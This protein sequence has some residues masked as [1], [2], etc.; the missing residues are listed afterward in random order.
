MAKVS[1]IPSF[2]HALKGDRHIWIWQCFQVYGTT[3]LLFVNEN[4]DYLS[5]GA[6]FRFHPNGV[7]FNTPRGY[8][9]IYSLKS[10]VKRSSFYTS[11][12][13]NASDANTLNSIDI[14]LHAKKR[15]LLN[16][17]F[18]QKSVS[19]S[20]TFINKHVDR[21]HELL[22]SSSDNDHRDWTEPINISERL[23]CLVFDILGDLCFG[24][25]FEIVGRHPR[26]K[27]S[28]FNYFMNYNNVSRVFLL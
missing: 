21:W 24:K 16:L 11:F 27:I 1:G 20:G 25:S 23:D 22:V 7:L 10:N 9:D 15:K 5:S 28:P 6:S 18:T 8:K 17:V 19:T 3:Y 4:I 26:S 13:R 14:T 2:Y 12:Q